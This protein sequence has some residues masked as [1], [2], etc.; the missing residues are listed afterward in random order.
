MI[1]E[2]HG[3]DTLIQVIMEFNKRTPFIM[4][5]DF[6]ISYTTNALRRIEIL[7]SLILE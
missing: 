7:K 1:D 2:T 3:R 4:L 5:N 6:R